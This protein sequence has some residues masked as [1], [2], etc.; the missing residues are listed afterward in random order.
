[1][2]YG[3]VFLVTKNRFLIS[4]IIIL[5]TI[6]FFCARQNYLCARQNYLCARQKSFREFSKFAMLQKSQ[7][8]NNFAEMKSHFQNNIHDFFKSRYMFSKWDNTKFCKWS[9]V[10]R[11]KLYL[12]SQW[13][14]LEM[15]VLFES[16]CI[17]LRMCYRTVY[18]YSPKTG[19]GGIAPHSAFKILSAFT[20]IYIYIY[21]YPSP[22]LSIYKRDRWP[23]TA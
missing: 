9:R 23:M 7:K 5:V 15:Y 2:T 1:M 13:F 8:W 6:I 19:G 10:C 22:P 21:I 18:P 16:F 3:V 11:Y 14:V 12:Q 17:I 20:Y 4:K